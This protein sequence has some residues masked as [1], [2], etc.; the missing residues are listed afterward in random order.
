M[1]QQLQFAYGDEEFAFGISKVDRSKLYGS[2][3]LKVYDEEKREC[4]L[5]TLAGDG[6]TLIPLGGTAFANLSPEGHWRDKDELKP[7]DLDG[8]EIEPVTSTFKTTTPLVKKASYEDYLSRNIRLIYLLETVEGVL[9]DELVQEL[10]DGV[11]YQFPFSYRGGLEADD[12]FLIAGEDDQI[13][14]TVGKKTDIQ[15]IGFEQAGA[16]VVEVE[17]E[18]DVDGLMDFGL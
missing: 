14:M 6:K 16:T 4:E 9:P 18:E 17:E 1:A 15:F 13:W 10:K 11:I 7:V 3:E 5:A 8:N 2:V 12:A